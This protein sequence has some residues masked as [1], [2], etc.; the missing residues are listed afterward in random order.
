MLQQSTWWVLFFARLVVVGRQPRREDLN[1]FPL[2]VI[3]VDA[4]VP[5]LYL[6]EVILA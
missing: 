1:R 3:Q 6:V 2:V 4:V 5:E